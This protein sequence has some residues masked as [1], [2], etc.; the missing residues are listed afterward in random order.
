VTLKP[1]LGVTQG[2]QTWYH[3]IQ[4]PRHRLSTLGRRAFSVAGPMAW[5]GRG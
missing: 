2:H 5:N 4:H 3:S 1:G